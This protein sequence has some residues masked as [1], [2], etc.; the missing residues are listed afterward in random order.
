MT[1]KTVKDTD[2][3]Q[4]SEIW[5]ETRRKYGTASEAASAMEVSPWV[6]KTRL[7]LWELKNGELEIKQNFAMK[8]GHDYEDEARDWA[9]HLLKKVYE[10]VCIIDDE[11]FGVPLMASL[12]GQEVFGGTSILEI[13]VPLNGG[14]SPLWAIMECDEEL[15]ENY[16]IQMT[17]QMMLSGETKC[18]FIVYDW[19]RKEGKHRTYHFDEEL[20]GRILDAWIL[21]FA[22][23]PQAGPKDIVK[24]NDP[25]WL[26]ATETW[27]DVKTAHEKLTKELGAAREYLIKTAEGQSFQGNGVRARRNPESG[28]FTIGRIK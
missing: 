3:P 27:K 21:Y 2:L 28:A 20:K 13:K 12:D 17:Q 23:K 10:P 9:Q 16:R 8:I 7:Q 1:I 15:P 4:G 19:K 26:L 18:E 5:L 11:T 6:P 22:G 24:R 14:C 25:E